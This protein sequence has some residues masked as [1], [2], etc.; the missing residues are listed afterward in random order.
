M[1]RLRQKIEPDANHPAHLIT[2]RGVGYR[3]VATNDGG[4][5]AAAPR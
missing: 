5:D 1:R 4:P 2:V 3:L